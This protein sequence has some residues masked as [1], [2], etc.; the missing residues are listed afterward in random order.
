[1]IAS[2]QARGCADEEWSRALRA[3]ALGAL[4][5]DEELW[6]RV[7]KHV[8]GDDPC[9]SCRR[10][11]RGLQG[12]A[13]ILPPLLPVGGH[14][15]PDAILAHLVRRRPRGWPGQPSPCRRLRRLGL[16]ARLA[17]AA[18]CSAPFSLPAP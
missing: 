12:L 15:G 1:M 18:A 4:D 14:A 10:Y 5:E 3:H 6:A 8:E 2:I 17:A 7:H 9:V 13:L 16:P 11:V